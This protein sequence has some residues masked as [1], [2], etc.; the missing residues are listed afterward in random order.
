MPGHAPTPPVFELEGEYSA[1]THKWTHDL[2]AFDDIGVMI[3]QDGKRVFVPYSEEAFPN[4]YRLRVVNLEDG[5]LVSDIALDWF[6]VPRLI[7]FTDPIGF[8]V[9]NNSGFTRSIAG[10]YMVSGKSGINLLFVWKD[11]VEFY[12]IE[13]PAGITA[14]GYVGMSYDGKYIIMKGSGAL[15][16]KLVCFEGD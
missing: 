15:K 6:Y 2:A 3:A 8:Q 10:R 16:T 4:D 13:M 9:V 5:S 14:E 11:G 1:W 7:G 12:E